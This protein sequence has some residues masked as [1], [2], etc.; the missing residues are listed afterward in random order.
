MLSALGAG[1]AVVGQ[2]LQFRTKSGEV[3]TGLFS[4][5]VLRLGQHPCIL[6]SI[7]DITDRKRAEEALRESEARY[8]LTLDAVNDGLWDWNVPTGDALF[9]PR[10]YALLGYDDGEFPANYA[11]WRLLVHPEDIDQVEKQL[12]LG[13]ESGAGFAIDL[14]MKMKSGR[15]LWVSIRGMTVERDA[16]GKA[17]R[18][19][20]TL[21][22]ITERK[23]AEE[24][25]HDL[26]ATLEQRVEERTVELAAAVKE[27]EAFSYS[28]SHD[29]RAPLRS[30]DGFSRI[31]LDEFAPALDP[32][33][34]RYLGLVRKNAQQMGQLV[35]D[36]LAFSRLGRRPLRRS[37]VEPADLVRECLSDLEPEYG[38]RAG[39]VVVG[40]LPSC[41]A[42]PALL[43]QVWLN[44]LAN[45]CKFTSARAPAEIRVGCRDDGGTAVYFVSDNGVGFDMAY[46]AKLFGV[47][48]RLHRAE[49]YEGTGVGLALVQRIVHRHGGRIWAESAA[50]RGA[51]FF[52]TLGEELA[53]G[54]E[55]S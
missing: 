6:S 46:A 32:A 52:F 43:K 26:N 49:D 40:P 13:V 9:S 50:D 30:L 38:T 42:D 4:A 24:A 21:S 31:L 11:S 15:W 2:E 20:G 19:V 1:R 53:N 41:D 14:R 16:A 25:L 47:F 54:R 33:A 8:A 7:A 36:L 45:A 12:G 23:R 48:Q 10:Y 3:I 39:A 37:R 29:L 34:Q 51:T 5:Q 55:G 17:L 18:L 27:L 35:D 22:D 28:V 44:L